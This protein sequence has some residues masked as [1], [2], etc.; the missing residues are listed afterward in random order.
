[1]TVTSLQGLLV[2]VPTPFDPATGDPAPVPLKQHAE[3]CLTAGVDGI[4][5]AGSTGEAAMLTEREFAQVLEWLRDVIPTG[6]TL[7]A[8]AGRESTRATIAAC[9]AA[10]DFGA[11]AVLVR[12]PSYFGSSLSPA[13]LERH[14]LEVAE[15][16]PVP[17]L[18]YN[19]PKYVHFALSDTLLAA[20]TT[21]PNVVGAKDSS[22]DLKNFTA[23]RAAAPQWAHFMG[24][25]SHFSAALE[26]GAVGGILAIANVVPD[27]AL[28]VM[29]RWRAGDPH[30]AAA[31]QERLTPLNKLIVGELGVP[32]VK[33]AMD[34]V[35]RPGGMVR[36]P[37]ADLDAAGRKRIAAALHAGGVLADSSSG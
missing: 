34:L 17:V 10:A 4:V 1:M 8:G 31:A 30:G 25:G 33:A 12:A 5:A 19:I 23:Y 7:V 6:G 20:L 36:P 11:D 35:G 37:L 26:L 18:V 15:V 16:S 14:F 3:A 2:P 32:G 29:R 21:H 9:R 22:G 24:S 13:A 28:E 27:L